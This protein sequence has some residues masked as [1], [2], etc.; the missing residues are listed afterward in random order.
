MN[1][2]PHRFVFYLEPASIKDDRVQFS[3]EES[4]H[5]RAVLRYDVG[6]VVEATDGE[7]SV[8]RI[9]LE[10]L[11]GG[12][13]SGCILDRISD[14]ATPPLAIRLALPCLKNDRWL[15]AFEAACE[16]GVEEIWPVDF[17]RVMVRWTNAR[18][19]KARRKAIE[20]LKQ[21]GGS[22]LTKVR[23]PMTF[24]ELLAKGTFNDLLL[25][26][27]EGERLLSLSEG[28]LLVVGPE[29]G[30]HA[31]EEMAFGHC[32]GRLFNLGKRR[33]RSEIAAVAAVS[34]AAS[35]LTKSPKG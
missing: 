24:V 5:L 18:L 7:G 6:Q 14:E 13:W 3:R 33:L 27:P 34:Q 25:A 29:A 15:L 22:H 21:A 32:G 26:D 12:C 30:L 4:H 17:S 31:E 20:I 28:A 16:F 10:E 1:M 23:D 35:I 11:A 19:V 9:R 2:N 8:Y